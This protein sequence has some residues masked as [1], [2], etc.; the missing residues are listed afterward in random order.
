MGHTDTQDITQ[1]KRFATDFRGTEISPSF[2]CSTSLVLVGN[3]HWKV[4]MKHSPLNRN[5][6]NVAMPSTG[7]V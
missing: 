4:G 5:I 7:H 1:P 2:W 3:L 6:I